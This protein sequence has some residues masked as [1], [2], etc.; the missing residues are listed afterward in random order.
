[1]ELNKD[2]LEAEFKTQLDFA[3]FT[4]SKLTSPIRKEFLQY[5]L[6]LINELTDEASSWKEI[7]EGY[8]K[9][10]EDCAEDRAKLTEENERLSKEV[11]RLSQVVLNHEGIT[12]MEVEEAIADTVRKMQTEIEAR[13]IKG[14]IYPAFVKSTIE[15]VAEEMIGGDTIEQEN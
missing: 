7:A 10:F 9:L 15:K 4:N 13:C 8:Q 2:M 11:D 14:G 1:M 12:E 3:N 6:S 5:A